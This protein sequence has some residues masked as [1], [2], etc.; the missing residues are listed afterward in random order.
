MLEF[1]S[2]ELE[3]LE[4]TPRY[5]RGITNKLKGNWEVDKYEPDSGLAA[6][7]KVLSCDLSGPQWLVSIQLGLSQCLEYG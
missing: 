1:D 3:A 4:Q 7:R 5:C 6:P 2:L